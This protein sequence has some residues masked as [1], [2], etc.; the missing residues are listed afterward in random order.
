MIYSA[1]YVELIKQNYLTVHILTVS[2]CKV[3]LLDRIYICIRLQK[4]AI[5]NQKHTIILYYY[6]IFVCG[7]CLHFEINTYLP[8]IA[9]LFHPHVTLK[10]VSETQTIH[11]KNSESYSVPFLKIIINQCN[12]NF[13]TI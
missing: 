7:V 6:C 2:W 3:F 5:C 1:L 11:K 9:Y 8:K 10:I 13:L 12:L 4:W